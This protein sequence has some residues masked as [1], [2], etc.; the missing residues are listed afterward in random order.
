MKEA[1]NK[2]HT[3][4][5]NKRKT[6]RSAMVNEFKEH[7]SR[8]VQKENYKHETRREK[9][10]KR[11]SNGERWSFFFVVVAAVNFAMGGNGALR[12]L[13]PSGQVIT[14]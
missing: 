3:H 12:N 7:Q 10:Q 2:T 13:L 11:P 4:T 8:A 1:P 14:T 9:Y 6:H 5:Q